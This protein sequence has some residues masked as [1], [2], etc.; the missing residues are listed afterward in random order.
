MLMPLVMRWSLNG[1]NS[2]SLALK[3]PDA[4][5]GVLATSE[6]KKHFFELHMERQIEHRV[7]FVFR[8]RFSIVVVRAFPV[9]AA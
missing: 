4:I 9:A 1:L 2:L 3:Q 6:R 8:T 7:L 5:A